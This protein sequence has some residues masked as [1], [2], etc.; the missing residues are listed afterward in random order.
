[1]MPCKFCGV[2]PPARG[3]KQV[4]K[5]AT[6]EIYFLRRYRCQDCAAVMVFHGDLLE[7]SSLVETWFPPGTVN[8]PAGELERIS[9]L[10]RVK[11]F[12]GQTIRL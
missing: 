4:G 8:V 6:R 11:G 12:N 2:D 3:L 7:R 1:M 5:T 9:F 10:A